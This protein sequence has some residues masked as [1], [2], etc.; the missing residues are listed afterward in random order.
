ME[1]KPILTKFLI[2]DDPY[3]MKPVHHN[4]TLKQIR[5]L[6]FLQDSIL[7]QYDGTSIDKEDEEDL[8][9]TD[10]CQDSK[11]VHLTQDSQKIN[12][13]AISNSKIQIKPLENATFLKKV[14]E[15]DLYLYPDWSKIEKD[16]FLADAQLKGKQQ[17][18]FQKLLTKVSPFSAQEEAQAK[19]LM[20][21]GQI[22]SGKTTLLNFFINFLTG[23][24]FS[25]NFRYILINE[26]TE[27]TQAQNIPGFGDTRGILQDQIISDQIRNFFL[28]H[29]D[30]IDAICFILEICGK[31][32]AENFVCMITF[33]DNDEPYVLRALSQPGDPYYQNEKGVLM[34]QP[35]S[36]FCDL[37]PLIKEP[38]YLKFNSAALFQNNKSANQMIKLFWELGIQSFDDFMKK[39]LYFLKRKNLQPGEYATIC[40][41]CNK[42]CHYPCYENIQECGCLQG[43][44]CTCCS[45][46]CHWTLHKSWTYRFEIKMIKTSIDIQE[47]KDVNCDAIVKKSEQFIVKIEKCI[48]RFNEIALR[49]GCLVSSD[50]YIEIMIISEENEKKP[51]FEGRIRALKEFQTSGM[52]AQDALNEDEATKEM[53]ALLLNN[54]RKN[55]QSHQNSECN[56]F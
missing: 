2:D 15:L 51:G 21:V 25:D 31:D 17:N 30:S 20:V 16:K 11:T 19:V 3:K 42:T 5:A 23:V 29:L 55:L 7:F 10:I 36:I 39:K 40:L 33:C 41:Q 38:W 44:N 26:Q 34:P 47:L 54:L 45:G 50:Q 4:Q 14:N 35:K 56:V 1:S 53:K 32:V 9:L 12:N 18:E 13:N 28:N 37:I 27:K 22:L 49:T 6:L 48:N 43:E 46:K 24:Q 8:N 52:N